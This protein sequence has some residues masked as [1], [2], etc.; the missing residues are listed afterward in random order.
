[1][2]MN[3]N[4]SS[5]VNLVTVLSLVKYLCQSLFKSE[6]IDSSWTRTFYRFSDEFLQGFGSIVS[7]AFFYVGDGSDQKSSI[8]HAGHLLRFY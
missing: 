8:L 7:L 1:M 2:M 4:I 3:Q 5:I 6:L